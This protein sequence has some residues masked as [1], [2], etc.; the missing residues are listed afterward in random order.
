MIYI[1]IYIHPILRLV[2]T[3]VEFS[4]YC[5]SAPFQNMM[6]NIHRVYHVYLLRFLCL[7]NMDMFFWNLHDAHPQAHQICPH[8]IIIYTCYIMFKN[9]FY[10]FCEI[11]W[12]NSV[13]IRLCIHL[14]SMHRLR[15]AERNSSNVYPSNWGRHGETLRVSKVQR[16]RS[17]A[18]KSR[19]CKVVVTRSRKVLG[20][21]SWRQSFRLLKKTL[22]RC[23]G[24][25]YIWVLSIFDRSDRCA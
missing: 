4:S 11:T 1:Y 20:F 8:Q 16:C 9:Y 19:R 22:P 12:H 14:L 24:F 10:V 6:Q 25:G 7:E 13:C 15:F 23:S 21:Q 5:T 3:D 17:F 18:A 2:H